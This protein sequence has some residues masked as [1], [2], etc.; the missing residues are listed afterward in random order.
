M[1]S[2]L[3]VCSSSASC[4]RNPGLGRTWTRFGS[5]WWVFK[6]WG[7]LMRSI[8]GKLMKSKIWDKLLMKC[9]KTAEEN[10]FAYKGNTFLPWD[11]TSRACWR[12]EYHKN[13]LKGKQHLKK[14]GKLNDQNWRNCICISANLKLSCNLTFFRNRWKNLL[15]SHILLHHEVGDHNCGWPDCN[16]CKWNLTEMCFATGQTWRDPCSSWHKRS[17]QFQLPV[18]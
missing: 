13:L 11:M 3:R 17:H 5:N 6:I 8:W 9:L 7:K 1:W 18:G 16:N 4:W 10:G 2:H 14:I 15:A 12:I